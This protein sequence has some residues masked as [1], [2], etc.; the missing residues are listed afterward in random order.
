[1]AESEYPNMLE[2]IRNRL[3]DLNRSERKVADAILRN[4]A[5]ATRSSI[6]TLARTA[7]VSE[8]TVNRFCRNFS[9][10]GFPDFKIRLAQSMASGTPYV[11]QSVDADDSV[12]VFADKIMR[13]TIVSLDKARKALDSQKLGQTIDYLIQAKQVAFFGMGGSAAVALDA[14][15]KFFRFNIPVTAY[16]DVLMQRMVAAGASTGDAIVLIS[17]T[18]RT[19]DL[20]E[21]AESAR[22][23]GA[24]VIAITAPDSPLADA[25]TIALEVT[26]TEDTEMYIPMTSRIIHLAIIDI[27]ATGVTL[28]RGA[29]FQAHLKK[30]KDSLKPTR[31][32]P[33]G[34]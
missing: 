20:V 14:Q 3:N 19:R 12:D 31:F 16:D 24:T 22:E 10:K 34:T 17:Y 30:I 9:T 7:D 11:S 26:T 32:P 27:L 5:V 8:P 4:P 21:I 33:K 28:K 6:A 18:G 23:N 29:D 2:A 25:C 13:S 1:M 15:H